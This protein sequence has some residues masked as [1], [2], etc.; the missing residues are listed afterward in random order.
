MIKRKKNTEKKMDGK[1]RREKDNK[2]RSISDRERKR[3]K[4][5]HKE[6]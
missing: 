5:Q 4:E 2:R 3:R 1:D 6:Q